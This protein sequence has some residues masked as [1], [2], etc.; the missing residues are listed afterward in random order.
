MDNTEY[1]SLAKFLHWSVVILIAIQFVSSWLMPEFQR[2]MNPDFFLNA[3]MSFGLI[4]FPLAVAALVVHFMYPVSK[5]EMNPPTLQGRAAAVMHYLLYALI[6]ILPINGW[7]AT[8][9]GGIAVNVFGIFTLPVLFVQGSQISNILAE[10][11]SVLASTMGLLAMGHIG[12]ALYHQ[13]VLKDSVL[14][15]M[16]PRIK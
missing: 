1:R 4:I 5:P 3:H 13:V 16:K 14:Q 6:F 15:R 7:A 8:S 9:L 10:T 11:H 2:N 12:A